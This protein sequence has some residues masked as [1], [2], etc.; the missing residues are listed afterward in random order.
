MKPE[1]AKR[2][3][4]ALNSG[5]YKQTKDVLCKLDENNKPSYCCLGVLCEL[6]RDE[7]HIKT[8][9]CDSWD[10][11]FDVLAY[12]GNIEILPEDVRKWAGMK[13]SKGIL[14]QTDPVYQ[15]NCLA[16]INDG[17]AGFD[18]MAE[19]IKEYYPVL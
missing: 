15:Q 17:G 5:V 8:A 9:V 18:E 11:C 12:A 2:W 1:I 16:S 19:L 7:N 10:E 3:I 14:P 4:D 6:Y 13:T